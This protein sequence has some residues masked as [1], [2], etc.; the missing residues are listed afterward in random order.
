MFSLRHHFFY[1][2]IIALLITTI[3][4][5][6]SDDFYTAY[7]ATM[8]RNR[9]AS[10][11]KHQTL[12][13]R[14]PTMTTIAIQNAMYGRRRSS[15]NLC[16]EPNPSDK[17]QISNCEAQTSEIKTTM[18]CNEK[19]YCELLV[20]PN[21]F[22]GDPCPNSTEYLTITYK[23]RLIMDE[24]KTRSTCSGTNLRLRCPQRAQNKK[25]PY[26]ITIYDVTNL[27]NAECDAKTLPP[28]MSYCEE[29]HEVL[30]KLI[31][32]KCQ[33]RTRCSILLPG[34]LCYSS[35]RVSY[36][37]LP[38]NFLTKNQPDQVYKII[39]ESTTSPSTTS[40]STTSS[41]TK[42]FS[43]TFTTTNWSWTSSDSDVISAHRMPP[44]SNT[45]SFNST[46][47]YLLAQLNP[48]LHFI[49]TMI[50]VIN[51]I[52]ANL[53]R[54]LMIIFLTTTIFLF[55]VVI[56][57]FF[58]YEANCCSKTPKR[59]NAKNDAKAISVT[60]QEVEGE[61]ESLLGAEEQLPVRNRIA[62]IWWKQLKRFWCQSRSSEHGTELMERNYRVVNRRD[63]SSDA[64]SDFND[65]L[66][67]SPVEGKDETRYSAFPVS[68][69]TSRFD[70][71]VAS[72][73]EYP[74]NPS[75]VVALTSPPPSMTSPTR[76][77]TASFF[78]TTAV[79]N[80]NQQRLHLY[81]RDR[82]PITINR[83]SP[84]DPPPF[85]TS[86]RY[87]PHPEV[88][89]SQSTPKI[90][91]A[92]PYHRTS[93][94]VTTSSHF[95]N[96]QSVLLRHHPPHS[97][98]TS[99]VTQP[100]TPRHESTTFVSLRHHTSQSNRDSNSERRGSFYDNSLPRDSPLYEY[101]QRQASVRHELPGTRN[102]NQ[103]FS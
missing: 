76:A 11:C 43:D 81:S 100:A 17:D 89:T 36:A 32:E 90:T 4:M 71:D 13:I 58:H 102:L 93:P 70:D 87:K 38:E 97:T 54:I 63:S 1:Y 56:F 19:R 68:S 62:G 88:M 47:S 72:I 3:T 96:T 77:Y 25:T 23:C 16:L 46:T 9:V 49:T 7:I 65:A 75:S 86:S 57:I 80:G 91:Q 99:Y 73:Y 52:E 6:S 50:S 8:M 42:S 103:Y 69:N 34:D 15:K 94:Y 39:R 67:T 12:K 2:V 83:L 28:T 29:A 85:P 78:P 59:E 95:R 22:G 53:D 92:Y 30:M 18:E 20:H 44:L 41:A 37:C 101:C 61:T 21:V 35:V 60:S 55:F 10:A 45:S 84:R 79:A 27:Q 48:P 40:S 98:F 66:M 33:R 5:T 24:M 14:C 51:Y 82:V 31:S 74:D 26:I 64:E